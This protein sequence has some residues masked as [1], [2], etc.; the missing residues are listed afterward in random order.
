MG[1]VLFQAEDSDA[2]ASAVLAEEAG[3]PCLFEH[4]RK[5]MRLRPIMFFSSRCKG[6]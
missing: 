2:S 5:G 3:G 1:V 6:A 4:I